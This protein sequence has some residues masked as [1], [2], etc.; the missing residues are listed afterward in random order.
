MLRTVH[1]PLIVAVVKTTCNSLDDRPTI[2]QIFNLFVVPK[3]MMGI[4]ISTVVMG[5]VAMRTASFM[6][7]IITAMIGIMI[8]GGGRHHF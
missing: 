1:G 2:K 3:V 4:A 7:D 5:I 8:L 6:G